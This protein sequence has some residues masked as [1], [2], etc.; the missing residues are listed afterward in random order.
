MKSKEELCARCALDMQR[1]VDG[2][3]NP[4]VWI[5][6]LSQQVKKLVALLQ[7]GKWQRRWVNRGAWNGLAIDLVVESVFVKADVWK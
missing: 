3:Q 6:E 4:G 2:N 1:D 5:A 7:G